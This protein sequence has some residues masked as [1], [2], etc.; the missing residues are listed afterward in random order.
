[1]KTI[2]YLIFLLLLVGLAL[3]QNT[4]LFTGTG[5]EGGALK[6]YIWGEVK[7]PGVYQLSGTPDI[8]E[9]ISTAGG[10]TARADLSRVTLVRSISPKRMRIN[11][12]NSL[13]QGNMI[14]LS[15]GD[16]VLVSTGFWNKVRDNLPIVTTLAIFA[17]LTLSI[18]QAQKK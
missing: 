10:P 3:G 15:P 7:S 6:V 1:M 4:K 14:F 11:I 2:K 8:I 16:V 17:N 13:N 9:L 12:K 5:Q 18:I